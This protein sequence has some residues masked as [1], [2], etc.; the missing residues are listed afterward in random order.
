MQLTVLNLTKMEE[1]SPE[2]L[3]N[4]MEKV[5]MTGKKTLWTKK[6]FLVKNNFSFSTEFS[7]DLYCRCVKPRA[8]CG[9]A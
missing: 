5:L 3:E 1:S 2:R 6:R 7:K 4:A 9:K 8:C